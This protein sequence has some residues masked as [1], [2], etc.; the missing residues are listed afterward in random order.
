MM[1]KPFKDMT[2]ST[3]RMVVASLIGQ[4][5]TL[6]LKDG[7]EHFVIIRG[8]A[9]PVE[10]MNRFQSRLI[11]A[12]YYSGDLLVSNM[13]SIATLE[14]RQRPIT[15]PEHPDYEEQKRVVRPLPR[16]NS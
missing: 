13:R 3:Q 10:E 12:D 6:T 9:T 7:A 2:L 8:C 15:D 4:P 16:R 1:S 5:A 14:P 11:A